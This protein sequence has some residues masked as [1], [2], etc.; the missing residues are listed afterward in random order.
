VREAQPA[1][2]AATRFAPVQAP[3]GEQA[4]RG[5][6]SRNPRDLNRSSRRD[7]RFSRNR[8]RRATA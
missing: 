7:D 8:G 2:A 5:R 1:A 4:R 6:D 3:S